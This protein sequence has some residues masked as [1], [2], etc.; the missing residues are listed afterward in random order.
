MVV[1]DTDRT[2]KIVNERTEKLFGYSRDE[3]IGQ[4]VEVL[5]PERFRETHPNDFARYVANPQA[6]PL[7]SELDLMGRHKDGSEI[8]VRISLTPFQTDEG[9]MI[10]SVIRPGWKSAAP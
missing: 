6:R 10:S 7:N 9:L 1:T 3:L 4:P 5:I 8:A 2:I